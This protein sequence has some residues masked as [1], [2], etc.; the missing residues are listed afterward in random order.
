[1]AIFTVTIDAYTNLPPSQIGYR[2]VNLTYNQIYVFTELDFTDTIPSYV[3]PEGDGVSSVKIVTIPTQGVLNLSGSP[4]N[5]L[6]EIPI[7]SITGGL[8]TYEADV[9]DEDGYSNNELT[10]D[11]SDTGSL[12]FSGLTPGVINFVVSEKDNLPPSVGDGGAIIDYG[13]TLIFTKAMFTSSTT[14]AYSDPEGDTAELLKIL[15]LPTLGTIYLDGVEV[16]INQVISF[17]DVDSG[18]LTYVPDLAD[19]DGDLQNFTFAI[20]DAGSGIFVE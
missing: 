14:P 17:N 1:M 5:A 15:S 7:A 11:L 18:L 13:N 20:A 6:D 19:T 10:F 9:L 12:T 16:V 4:V 8:L 2:G 3:D